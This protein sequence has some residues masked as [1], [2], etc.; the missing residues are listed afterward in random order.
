MRQENEDHLCGLVVRVPGCKPRGS[1][2]YSR[3]YQICCIV[4]GLEWGPLSLV[5]INEELL[6]RKVVAVV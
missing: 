4:M 3:C 2:F 5:K 6:E 1:W